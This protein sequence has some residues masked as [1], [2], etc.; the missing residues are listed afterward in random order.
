MTDRPRAG[1][2]C[3][4]LSAPTIAQ[5]AALAIV[6]AVGAPVGAGR[7]S[8]QETAAP[9]E[10]PVPP[11]S[12]DRIRASLVRPPSRPD[13]DAVD[14][15]AL[16]FRV[17]AFP[18]VVVGELLA[19]G[20]GLLQPTK[21]SFVDQYIRPIEEWGVVPTFGSFGPRSGFLGLTLRFERFRPWFV[22]AGFSAR[23]SQL[24][25]TG[26][27]LEGA[28]GVVELAYTFR[29]NPELLFWGVGPESA[30]DEES[31]FLGKSSTIG[32]TG[33]TGTGRLY[34][35]GQAEWTQTVTDA[36]LD[37][38]LPDIC[39]T[40][41]CSALIGARE[42]L[43]HLH[44]GVM[45]RLDFSRTRGFQRRGLVLEGSGDLYLG[46]G[47]TDSDF[48]RIRGRF[49]GYLPINLRQSLAVQGLVTVTRPDA[50]SG[51]PFYRLAQLG[52]EAGGRAYPPGR[53]ADRD[54]AALMLDWRY[55][56]WRELH[57]E[58]RLEWVLFS[59]VGG[60]K[61]NL[62]DL[63]S[64]DLKWSYGFGLQWKRHARLRLITLVAFGEERT[65]L[66][67]ET[68]WAY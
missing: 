37:D 68:K 33:M 18:L 1:F 67:V 56:I 15:V 51:I 23:L 39:Q 62:T 21:P 40:F 55:E 41:D 19:E 27:R 30:R 35:T 8:A 25:R 61:E 10:G 52:D 29:R 65:R 46:V 4:R 54:L 32:M 5:A 48:H 53:F 9:A 49:V 66:K 34:V 26:V 14:I 17:A 58:A 44:L 7:A 50:G 20:V 6:L 57:E 60:V 43:R 38:D 45:A 24:A 13:P 12:A 2:S 11:D 64:S 16:P 42:T 22:E 47:G 36:G 63:T 31:D 3:G 59:D 28:P